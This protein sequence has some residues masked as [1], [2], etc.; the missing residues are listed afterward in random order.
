[1]STP[2][3]TL[4]NDQPLGFCEICK[5]NTKDKEVHDLLKLDDTIIIKYLNSK[6]FYLEGTEKALKDIIKGQKRTIKKLNRSLLKI[7]KDN[8]LD[9]RVIIGTRGS[10]TYKK[11]AEYTK[12]LESILNNQDRNNNYDFKYKI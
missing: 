2:R 6:I 1:M 7:K 10:S 11:L 4:H 12:E 8:K 3:C 5:P 9:K